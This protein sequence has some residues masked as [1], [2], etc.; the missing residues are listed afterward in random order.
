VKP[1]SLSR[2][3]AGADVRRRDGASA[4]V[5]LACQRYKLDVLYSG[6]TF[7]GRAI[8]EG[9]RQEAG[10]TLRATVVFPALFERTSWTPAPNRSYELSSLDVN[11]I[12]LRPTAQG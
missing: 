2:R 9:L 3:Y 7:A 1:F 12:I 4:L 11:E 6:T 5:N 8:S 10:D